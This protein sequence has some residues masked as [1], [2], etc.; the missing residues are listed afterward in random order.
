MIKL[1]KLL[2]GSGVITTLDGTGGDVWHNCPEHVKENKTGL[3][4][5]VIGHS[6][7]EAGDVNYIDVDFGNGK[8]YENL[9]KNQ[10]KV[11]SES[12]HK[13]PVK[14]EPNKYSH[15][16]W[17]SG[18]SGEISGYYLMKQLK[19]LSID[20]AQSDEP[21]LAAAYQWLR[22][23]VNQSYR[24]IDLNIVDIQDLL[25]EPSGRKHSSNLPIEYLEA[26][27]DF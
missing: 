10:F 19:D 27:F 21:A 22:D 7:N 20:A 26:L 12:S 4:G 13:H 18:A 24:D 11:L 9:P 6:L 1:K 3:E 5:T 17:K 16:D 14:E 15:E 2:E 8:V 23:R 25:N